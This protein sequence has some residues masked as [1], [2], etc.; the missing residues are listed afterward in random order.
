MFGGGSLFIFASWNMVVMTDVPKAT[1]YH[2]VILEREVMSR[3]EN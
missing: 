2:E 3:I 1:R